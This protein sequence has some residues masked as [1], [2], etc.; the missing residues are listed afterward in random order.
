MK[1]HT[2][3]AINTNNTSSLTNPILAQHGEIIPN[4]R[5]VYVI[6]RKWPTI[7]D[8][9]DAESRI[10]TVNSYKMS[11]FGDADDVFSVLFHERVTP[12]GQQEPL[13]RKTTDD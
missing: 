11:G 1:C 6:L 2:R 4:L 10:Q 5:I 3:R 13:V 12:I 9:E 8:D 7:Q